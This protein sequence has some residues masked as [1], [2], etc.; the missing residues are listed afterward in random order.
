MTEI[1]DK[2][3]DG[4]MPDPY[5]EEI[6]KNLNKFEKFYHFGSNIIEQDASVNIDRRTWNRYELGKNRITIQKLIELS[7][8]QYLKDQNVDLND[9]FRLIIVSAVEKVDKDGN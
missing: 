1:Q 7:K 3:T 2:P 5:K 9:I 8:L 4:Q 6:A